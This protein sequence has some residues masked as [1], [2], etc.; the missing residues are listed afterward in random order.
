MEKAEKKHWIIR[1]LL[2]PQRGM[3]TE[4][5]E[6]GDSDLSWFSNLSCDMWG[7]LCI[8]LRTLFVLVK[9][10]MLSKKTPLL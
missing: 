5:F 7:K 10:P 6:S 9:M 8:P 3:K 1:F 2:L 4:D